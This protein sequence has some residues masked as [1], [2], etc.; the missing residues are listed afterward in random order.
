MIFSFCSNLK[1]EKKL[2]NYKD[3]QKIKVDK[4]R[5]T[6]EDKKKIKV[7]RSGKIYEIYRFGGKTAKCP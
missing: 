4:N 2:N 5:E 3:R 7:K 6:E 1:C